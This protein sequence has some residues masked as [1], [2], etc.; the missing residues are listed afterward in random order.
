MNRNRET[1]IKR[2]GVASISP[3]INLKIIAK[4][5]PYCE[6]KGIRDQSTIL[7]DRKYL[8]DEPIDSDAKDWK[9]CYLCGKT[10]H[11]VHEP[12][13]EPELIS[14]IDEL[15]SPYEQSS[16]RIGGIDKRKLGKRSNN[17]REK[18]K[19]NLIKDEEV[20]EA[21]RKG[22]KLLNYSET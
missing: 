9:Q 20:R 4:Y 2:G 15:A 3:K 7:G 19:I 11:K 21:L 13:D 5:C 6:E 17:K 22:A 8:P 16:G 18:S 10:I 1:I 12:P 14:T